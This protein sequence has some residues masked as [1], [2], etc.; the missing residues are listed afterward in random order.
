MSGAL[1]CPPSLGS[2]SSRAPRRGLPTWWAMD[3]RK[4]FL[5]SFPDSRVLAGVQLVK[6]SRHVKGLLIQKPAGGP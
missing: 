1:A 2:P 6:A 5:Q 3:D 4:L